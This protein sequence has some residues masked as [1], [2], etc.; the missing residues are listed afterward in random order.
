MGEMASKYKPLADHLAGLRADQVKLTFAEVERVAR[1]TL[2]RTAYEHP[3]WWAN[4][5]TRDSHGW[6]HL[7][8]QAG[9]ESHN[10]D[11]QAMT[12]E[13]RRAGAN[14]AMPTIASLYPTKLEHL[15]DL[16]TAASIDVSSWA[17][18][19][20][21]SRVEHPKANPDYCY[22]WSFGTEEEGFVLCLWCDLM[23]DTGGR[24]IYTE[25]VREYAR[26]LERTAYTVRGDAE[27]RSRVL[28]QARRARAFDTALEISYRKGKPVRVIMNAGDLRSREEI[29]EKSSKVALRAL[30]SEAWF[31]H[32]YQHET[33]DCLLVRSELPDGESVFESAPS[34]EEDLGPDDAKR[35]AEVKVRRGQAEFRVKLLAAYS[36]RC[37]VT[38]SRVVELLES[39]HIVPHAEETNYRTSNGLLLRADIH[40]LYD[41]HLLS[42]DDKC[43]IHMSEVLKG[44]EYWAHIGKTLAVLPDNFRD[45]PS[46]TSLASRHERFKSVDS[47]RPIAGPKV[48]R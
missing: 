9:W 3:A 18:R 1:L 17:F 37:A 23:D 35:L 19:G 31:A 39:A 33:G 21:G 20:D 14:G 28:Q 38:G 27:R 10:V 2:P 16:L 24:I 25:N 15:M 4:S 46:P 48:A 30:D 44:T 43:S 12:I 13:F 47:K 41:L 36:R 6:A 29:A 40:T 32:R 5:R 45:Q 34:E 7:W 42:I 22:D 26:L 8:L 11:L